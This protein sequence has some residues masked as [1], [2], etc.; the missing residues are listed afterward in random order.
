MTGQQLR[1]KRHDV[2]CRWSNLLTSSW[3]GPPITMVTVLTKLY[4]T[5]IARVH[6]SGVNMAGILKGRRVDPECLVGAKG[7][8]RVPLASG[9]GAVPLPKKTNG[10]FYLK[11]HV[12]VHSERYFL[13]VYLPEKC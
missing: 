13:S 10:I 5:V 12:L 6:F 3:S 1:G 9:E 8:E 11:W 4:K 7:E 2:T